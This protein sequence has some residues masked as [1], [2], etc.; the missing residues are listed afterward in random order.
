VT[1]NVRIQVT[2]PNGQVMTGVSGSLY[3]SQGFLRY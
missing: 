1:P 2:D 3:D